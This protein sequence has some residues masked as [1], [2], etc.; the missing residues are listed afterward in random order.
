[1]IKLT[2]GKYPFLYE[3]DNTVT[4]NNPISTDNN[5]PIIEGIA[6]FCAANRAYGNQFNQGWNNLASAI[7]NVQRQIS[8][9]SSAQNTNKNIQT[10]SSG[11]DINPYKTIC[12][13]S[14]TIYESVG[15]KASNGY[16]RAYSPD[17]ESYR[18][19]IRVDA[20]GN[21][22]GLNIKL[23]NNSEKYIFVYED[24]NGNTWEVTIGNATNK[25]TSCQ[26]GGYTLY[27]TS[28]KT[29]VGYG[30]DSRDANGK[31]KN[32]EHKNSGAELR[33]NGMK[34]IYTETIAN[35]VNLG[36][37]ILIAIA[38]IAKSQ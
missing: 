22:N 31:L 37:G 23:I 11:S 30:R 24:A 10:S 4:D 9:S 38:F 21:F 34:S 19:S 14:G 27:K 16:I 36:V 29:I 6:D 28:T 33:Y 17:G 26:S 12:K 15:V 20:D 18:G 2:G 5:E 7:N 32:T 3:K 1:M 35:T 8:N 13:V 25:E